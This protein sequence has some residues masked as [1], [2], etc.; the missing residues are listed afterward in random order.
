MSGAARVRAQAK[1][2]LFLRVLAREESG[3]HLI[4]TLFCRLELADDVV[5]R[6]GGA[7]RRV[8][9]VGADVG[10]PERNLAFRAA[11]VFAEEARWPPGF[12]IEI[13][14]RIPIGGGLGGGSADAGAV[15]RALNALA[16]APLVGSAV[17]E[18]AA[19]VGA[20]VPFL[21][22]EWPLALA[23]GR[24]ERLLGLAPLSSRET[25]LVVPSFG[26]STADAYAWLDAGQR[27]AGA[28]GAS[29]RAAYSLDDL[30][31]WDAVAA[32]AE[33]DFEPAVMRRHPELA[34]QLA[35]LRATGATLARL[36]GS[37][38][39]LFAVLPEGAPRV[40]ES[41]FPGCRSIR[42]RTAER[43]APVERLG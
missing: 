41:A 4:E 9:V 11:T 34:E 32:I 14:K 31:S 20:D 2:N 36:S 13:E 28:R 1:V 23:W 35:R 10:P 17:F 29:R 37:G 26:V 33:N 40:A 30:A 19:R 15:L 38:S 12:A 21:A 42:T 39:A 3:Y 8:D 16:P 24:G 43:V 25:V 5:V 18:I 22:S 7:G 6:V 27:A